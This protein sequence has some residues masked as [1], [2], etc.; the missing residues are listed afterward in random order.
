MKR[1]QEQNDIPASVK[2]IKGIYAGE[3][4]CDAPLKTSLG[5]CNKKAYYKVGCHI[6][7]G[8]HSNQEPREVL[9]VNPR[10]KEIEEVEYAQQAAEVQEA[11][12]RNKEAG[13]PGTVVLSKMQMMKKPT[14]RAGYLN[15]FPNYL[16]ANRRGGL[17]LATLSPKAIGPVVHGQPGL[18]I[19]KNLENFHQ[20]NKVFEIEISKRG[21][22]L[23]IFYATQLA[24]YNDAR[25]HRHKESAKKRPK[26]TN[27]NRPIC[28]MWV[29]PDGTR[30]KMSYV[31]S[32]QFYCTFY[33]R[34]V[35]AL[36]EFA[37]LRQRIAE[38]TNVQLCGYDAYQPTQDLEQCYL[39]DMRPF[40]HELVLYCL[41]ILSPENYP[42]K[43]HIT[44]VF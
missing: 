43:K 26:G 8:T 28:S 35:L 9:P 7:C 17:G 30:K 24:M 5:T 4:V 44:Q 18:P 27:K 10:K 13:R 32:R 12:Q 34:H 19:A 31:E 20:G 22:I 1:I 36:P 11:I 38:G 41:L 39:D 14:Y 6:R 21:D 23:P 3:H 37:L 29:L 16:D 2:R 25:P 40:G 42:W 15:V 33:E